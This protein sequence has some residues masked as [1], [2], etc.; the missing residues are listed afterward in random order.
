MHEHAHE[1][2]QDSNKELLKKYGFKTTKQRL[3]VVS[4][5]MDGC[6][7]LSPEE[8]Y[9]KVAKKDT[10]DLATVYRTLS[11][12]EKAGI[13]KRVDIRN[14]S[15]QYELVQGNNHHHHHIMCTSCGAIEGFAV[16]NIEPVLKSA[17]KV[18]KKFSNISDH[19]LELYGV[20]KGC[21][22]K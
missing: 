12:F 16:C 1:H 18:S 15:A 21:D 20:C 4:V 7:P 2:T 19:S 11:A 6:N 8:V 22:K 3:A 13:L 9:K 17:A 14:G 10:L 5:F